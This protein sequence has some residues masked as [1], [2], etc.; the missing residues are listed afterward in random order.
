[1]W[2]VLKKEDEDSYFNSYPYLNEKRD[3]YKLYES[4]EKIILP[5]FFKDNYPSPLINE[6]N[7]PYK[8]E[9][10]SFA[11]NIV[12]RQMQIDV[13]ERI[14]EIINE[15]GCING[16]VKARPGSGKTILS[17]YIASL[18][19][20]KT[21][22][23]VDSTSLMEQ[24]IKAIASVTDLEPTDIGLIKQS[25]F[26]CSTDK[27]IVA[28][29]QSLLSQ[30]KRAPQDLYI[31]LKSLGIGLAFLDECHRSSASEQYS[32]ISTILPMNNIIG[33]SATPF[34][35]NEQAVLMENVIGPIIYNSNDYEFKPDVGIIYY[36]SKLTKYRGALG[37]I[38]DFI[39][40]RAFYSKI[41][42]KSKEFLGLFPKFIK[43]DL[44]NGHKTI[45]ICQTEAQIK[46]ISEEL[47]KHNITHR[48]YYGKAREYDT[49]DNVL[50]VTNSFAGTGFDFKEL[51]SLIY[52]IPL[53]GKVS[54]IQTAGRIL[55]SCEG[56]K[57]PIIRYLVDLSF[58]TQSFK[59]LNMMRKVFTDEFGEVNFHEI[60]MPPL[61]NDDKEE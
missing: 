15:K 59:E 57:Q 13:V 24:W 25:R 56:K 54:L 49:S 50:L 33:L 48:L 44:K 58:P 43:D 2:S 9:S 28:T 10:I 5:R 42:C 19:G 16:I 30:Y 4:E 35:H 27:I 26:P 60:N 41:I 29:V 20:L 51:S 52:A 37:R 22:I 7:P 61:Y 40:R 17:I 21:L 47:K 45:V 18:I 3:V 32:K 39:A 11:C 1:M 8:P 31:K 38:Q 53:C 34:L 46:S 55:R 14:K 36:K 12:P 23:I 6:V